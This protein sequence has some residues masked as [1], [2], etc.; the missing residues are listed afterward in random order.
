MKTKKKASNNYYFKNKVLYL[1]F[2]QRK[3]NIENIWFM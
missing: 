3:L 1:S 2:L